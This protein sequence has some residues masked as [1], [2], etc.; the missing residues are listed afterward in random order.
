MIVTSS[1]ESTPRVYMH[2]CIHVHPYKYICIN[3]SVYIYYN[4]HTHTNLWFAVS[5]QRFVLCMHLFK[6]WQ[7]EKKLMNL[8]EMD[9]LMR[10]PFSQMWLTK[11]SQ[12]LI[13]NV[14]LIPIANMASFNYCAV[15]QMRLRCWRWVNYNFHCALTPMTWLDY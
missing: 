12:M 11:N 7:Y 2:I 4:T 5:T 1:K 3:V 9:I 15:K 13:Y 14:V 6:Q 8:K 10:H